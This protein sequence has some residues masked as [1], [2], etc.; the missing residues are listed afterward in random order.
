MKSFYLF[1]VL[2]FVS[3]ATFANTVEELFTQANQAYEANDFTKA[4][5]TYEK[6]LAEGYESAALYYNLGN[7]YYKKSDLGRS[8]LNY[9]RA[10]RIDASDEDILQNLA[11]AREQRQDDIGVLPPF[12]L[13]R[14]W[15]GL[16]GLCSA[17]TW[18]IL[19]LLLL[20]MSIGGLAL[21]L[22]G[23][24]RSK[25]KQG[26]LL[27]FVAG[28]LSILVFTLAYQQA[29]LEANSGMAIIIET[30]IALRN[31]PDQASEAQLELHAGTK[32]EL[33]DQIGNWYKVRLMNGEQGWLPA[34]AV[35]Q[36]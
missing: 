15:A 5:D 13:A 18:S 23:E 2:L 14:W 34:P 4:L 27:A 20:W 31:A 12:F 33:L 10:L 8:I 30:E 3:N 29:Q 1:F 9:E 7:C 28:A 19:A 21:W 17:T 24:T 25:R 6:I 16:R 22:K 11:L 36:I 26:F 32:V 35:T